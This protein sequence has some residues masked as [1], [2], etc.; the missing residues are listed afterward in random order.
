MVPNKGAIAICE[1]GHRGL[2]TSAIP[3][4]GIW[5]GLHMGPDMVGKPWQSKKPNVLRYTS[6]STFKM[7]LATMERATKMYG[8]H[9]PSQDPA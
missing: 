8:L 5:H 2:I 4:K 9:N 7:L 6:P 3:V 1:A